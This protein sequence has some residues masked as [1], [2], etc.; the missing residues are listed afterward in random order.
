MTGR[1][2]AVIPA[3]HTTWHGPAVTDALIGRRCRCDVVMLS[4]TKTRQ[5]MGEALIARPD[6]WGDC[7]HLR[8]LWHISSSCLFC[9]H[10]IPKAA[11]QHPSTTFPP[12][13]WLV[14]E[15]WA[16]WD[17][18]I[19]GGLK[20]IQCAFVLWSPFIYL[21][22]RNVC[23]SSHQRCMNPSIHPDGSSWTQGCRGLMELLPAVR[24]EAGWDPGQVGIALPHRKPKKRQTTIH[25]LTHLRQFRIAVI[26]IHNVKI[27]NQFVVVRWHNTGTNVSFSYIIG[28]LASFQTGI[29]TG[30]DSSFHSNTPNQSLNEP[31]K[32]A[33]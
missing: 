27:Y 10:S 15:A 18:G 33:F 19:L 9:E 30:S 21:Q 4:E 3:L 2:G 25:S 31:N 16:Q 29:L 28:P 7:C 24:V 26:T 14:F 8:G 20:C 12:W 22:K 11:P 23:L 17:L 13:P 5:T 32:L 1:L 6:H